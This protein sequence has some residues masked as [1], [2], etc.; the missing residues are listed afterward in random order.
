VAAIDRRIAEL[1]AL[2]AELVELDA[3]AEQLPPPAAGG[4]CP[5]VHVNEDLSGVGR[6]PRPGRRCGRRDGHR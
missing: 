2:R 3:K 1:Q 4:Y 5:L 6:A